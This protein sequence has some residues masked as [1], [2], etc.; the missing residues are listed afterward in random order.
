MT[1]KGSKAGPLQTKHAS[2]MTSLSGQQ[3][4]V[5]GAFMFGFYN[6]HRKISTLKDL[7]RQPS[8]LESIF[9]FRV[10]DICE[11]KRNLNAKDT[12]ADFLK[13]NRY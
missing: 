8:A 6:S 3:G 7:A 5:E 13:R 10:N 12:L 9:I 11:Q 4:V 2:N 1:T